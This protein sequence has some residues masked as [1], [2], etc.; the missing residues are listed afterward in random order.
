[1]T[2]GQSRRMGGDKSKL[3]VNGERIGQRTAAALRNAGYEVTALGREP[4][5]GCRFLSDL[6]MFEGP[7][8]AL[9]RFEP[10]CEHVFVAS[11]D[12]PLFDARIVELFWMHVSPLD[13]EVPF[14][15]GSLQPT[16]A[17]Y[18]ARCWPEAKNLVKFGKRSMMAWLDTL[19]INAHDETV[20]REAG[21]DPRTCLGANTPE[22][23][24]ALTDRV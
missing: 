5:I 9:A 6:G 21:I 14:I 19:Q 15:V 1:M 2:G 4:L 22:E 10:S 13:A 18:R 23:F 12:M 16:C 17:L 7:L 11:C 8:S 20:F 3:E 24:R